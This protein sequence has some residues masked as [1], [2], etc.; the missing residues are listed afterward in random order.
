MGTG[1]AHITLKPIGEN[2]MGAYLRATR[3][4]SLASLNP[5]W[6]AAIRAY[7]EKNELGDLEGSSLMCCETTSTKQKQ[8]LFGSKTEVSISAALCTPK[9]LVLASGKENESPSV[10]SARLRDIRALDYE[11]SDSYKLIQ[12]SGLD[13]SGLQTGTP[14]QGSI[15]IGL[16]PEP[17]AQK[18]RTVL[19]ESIEKAN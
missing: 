12:D 2:E 5:K 11:K 19:K 18:F 9:W 16:G 15:F 3:E 4:C 17:A 10:L 8:G 6:S 1:T 14:E 13:I 7:I